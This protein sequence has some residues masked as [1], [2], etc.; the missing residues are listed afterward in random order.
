[1]TRETVFF[2]TPARRA[3]SLM[4]ARPT[5]GASAAGFAA[6]AAVR[7]VVGFVPAVGTGRC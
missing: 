3:M 2:E 6:F 1:M 7:V 4:V 5:G